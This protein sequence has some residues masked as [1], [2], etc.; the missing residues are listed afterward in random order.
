[1]FAIALR[2]V[3]KKKM[4]LVRDHFGIKPLYYSIFDDKL[5]FSSEIKPIFL[6]GLIKRA[7]NDRIIYRYLKFRVHDDG[8]ET[9]F[10]NIYRL[11]PGDL[12]EIRNSKFEV[13]KY[14]YLEKELYSSSA[15]EK[16]SSRQ[17]RTIM[18]FKKE[19]I[20]AIKYRLI[21]DVPVGTCLSGGLDSSTVVAV[22]NNLLKNHVKEAKSVGR[23]QKTFS[24]VCPGSTND[25]ERYIDALIS[26]MTNIKPYKINPNPKEFFEDLKE[27][28]KI[29]EEP[30]ISTGPYAQYKV[31]EMAQGKVK[32]LLDGQGSDEMMA[33]YMPYYMVYFRQLMK[34][35]KYLKLLTEAATSIDVI[36]RYVKDRLSPP[37]P[38][39]NL[40]K[41]SFVD[42]FKVE[43]FSV[44]GDNL[45]KRL[46]E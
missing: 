31:M 45:K 19:L 35:G 43:K 37:A 2:D 25:E 39:T 26:K 22:V 42:R 16:N 46:V 13:R 8:R 18:D 32:V 44:V 9:F 20:R 24:A 5:V 4:F 29:Q 10:K 12:I 14:S 41:K 15:V 36:S 34:E 40:L 33:G 1:M 21:S 30:T 38:I 23:I 27:F 6:S 28:I 7:P 3:K 17:A 11:R